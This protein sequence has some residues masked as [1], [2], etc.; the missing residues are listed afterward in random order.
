MAPLLE[1]TVDLGG[2]WELPAQQ[3]VEVLNAALSRWKPR[4]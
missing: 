2:Y 4:T 3:V 1:G